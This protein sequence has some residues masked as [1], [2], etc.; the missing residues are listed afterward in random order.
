[1]EERKFIISRYIKRGDTGGWSRDHIYDVTDGSAWRSICGDTATGNVSGRFAKS[2][3][4]VLKRMT[5]SRRSYNRRQPC[6]RCLR[7]AQKLRSPLDRMAEIAAD[8]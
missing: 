4:V 5:Q 7:A 2:I 1:M 6:K 8:G 3:E